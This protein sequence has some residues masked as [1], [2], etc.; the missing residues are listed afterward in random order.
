[1]NTFHI[2]G[3]TNYISRFLFK[4]KNV[5]YD[6]FYEKLFE[7]IKKD[8][9]LHS[10]IERI[11]DHYGNWIEYGKIDH[12]PIQNIEIHGWNLV[13]STIINMQS[14]RKASH[15]FAVIRDFVKSNFNIEDSIFEQLIDFQSSYIIDQSKM[16]DYPKT[17]NT[18]YDFLGYIQGANELT[19][20]STYE[21]EF[22]EDKTMSLQQ[23]CEQIFFAR[24]RNFG[25]AWITKK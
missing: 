10:E 3:L 17:V 21:F 15:V 20:P 6:E 4:Y 23:F 16:T 9:W 11:R 24:R 12:V 14:E 8:E 2:N 18:D 19:V 13:H 7:H 5:E 22:P 25:K 1:M